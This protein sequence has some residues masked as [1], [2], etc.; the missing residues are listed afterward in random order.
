MSRLAVIFIA[1]LFFGCAPTAKQ[2][3]VESLLAGDTRELLHTLREG[4][5]AN[6]KNT[7][8][9]ELEARRLALASAAPDEKMPLEPKAV[10]AAILEQTE[11]Q[12]LLSDAAFENLHKAASGSSHATKNAYASALAGYL[13]QENF[14]CQQP[15]Y[16]RYFDDRYAPGRAAPEC[17]GQIPFSVTTQYEGTPVTWVDPRRVSSIHL[18]FASKSDNMASRFGHIALR[19]VVCPDGYT[20]EAECDSNLNEHLVLGFRAHID[21]FSLNSFKALSGEYRAYLFANRFMD[22]YQEYA[23]GEFREIYSLPLRLD[24]VERE[25]VVRGLADIHWRYAGRYS[26][27]THNCATMTQ[28]ALRATWPAFAKAEA[29]ADD[30][31][32]PDSLFEA[33][34]LSSHL[35]AKDKLEA[36]EAAERGGYF[37]SSTREFYDRALNEV[38]NAMSNPKFVDLESYLQI[39]PIERRQ[40]RAADRG[41]L[42]RLAADRHLKEAQLMLEEYAIL[43]S[44]RLMQIE[45]AKYFEQQDFIA[46]ADD[47]RS[48]LDAEHFRVFE[49]CLLEPIRQHQAPM[50]KAD[51]IPDR[52]DLPGINGEE[53]ACR[54]PLNRKLLHEAIA[55]IENSKS[56]QWQVLN[57]ISQYCAES[58]ANLKLL[59]PNLNAA[60]TGG[61]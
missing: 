11:N 16:S 13:T 50:R 40:D 3:A 5:P 54:S 33:V 42:L 51:G 41:F 60:T 58:I 59:D 43:R 10:L 61:Q 18:L 26:F 34:R 15:L 28:D 19:L 6:L 1:A 56:Q 24:V 8:A 47:I 35:A 30:Y 57:A 20:T 39:D 38:K 21:E 9:S 17:R 22:V 27:F 25:A 46:K 44:E 29:M 7:I 48:R 49:D 31:V 53:T 45:G 12:F 37:F 23:I 4:A 52:K 36:L 2:H 55:G 14:A 32:R